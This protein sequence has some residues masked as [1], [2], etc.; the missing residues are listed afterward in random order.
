MGALQPDEVLRID[1][2]IIKPVLKAAAGS[3]SYSLTDPE[4]ANRPT[5]SQFILCSYPTRPAKY[6]YIVIEVLTSSGGRVDIR[7]SLFKYQVTVRFLVRAKVKTHCHNIINGINEALERN[8][9]STSESGFSDVRMT[10]SSQIV[11]V[12][13]TKI[14]ARTLTV[15][16]LVYSAYTA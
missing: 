3:G 4:A 7:E 6:P 11:W 10:G 16:G 5:N 1:E 13:G 14:Y 9:L 15:Q 2:D 8:W 12:P